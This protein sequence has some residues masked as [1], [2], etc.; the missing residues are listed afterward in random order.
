MSVAGLF[1][2]ERRVVAWWYPAAPIL[3]IFGCVAIGL[4][5]LMHDPL[6]ALLGVAMVLA[7]GLLRYFFNKPMVVTPARAAIAT[8]EENL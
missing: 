3:F 5:I 1:R 6:P 4:L 7:G 2:L 8:S